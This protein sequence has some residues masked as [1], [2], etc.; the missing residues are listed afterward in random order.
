M[1]IAPQIVHI[2][3]HI[4]ETHEAKCTTLKVVRGSGSE[5]DR[6]PPGASVKKIFSVYRVDNAETLENTFYQPIIEYS[7]INNSVKW[8]SG[9]GPD[10]GTEYCVDVYLVQS[11]IEEYI[12][13]DCPR[14][15]GN[16]WYADLMA[17]SE[18][19]IDRLAGISKIV[20]DF[21]K[22]LFTYRE[23]G[24]TYGTKLL[25]LI[26]QEVTDENQLT[27]EVASMI[28]NAG[29]KYKELQ[30]SS[31]VDGNNLDDDEILDKV[32]I[33][34]ISFDPA[35]GGVYVLVRLYSRDGTMRELG[36]GV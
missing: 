10:T 35:N 36:V 1:T 34:D 9:T 8:G 28:V 4:I 5:V 12:S 25:D 33:G 24:G 11:R 20:Q 7:L 21:I 6:F 14:C 16:G 23:D 27:S 2:C 32:I 13:E 31:I 15:N 17:Q 19:N 29:N 26:G 30:S 3:D 18:K 22:I